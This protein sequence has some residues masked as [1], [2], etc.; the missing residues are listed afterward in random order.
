MR[1]IA[2][3]WFE[4]SVVL[5][6]AQSPFE[7]ADQRTHQVSH[8][9]CARAAGVWIVGGEAGHENGNYIEHFLTGFN[10]LGQ[11]V[12]EI[13]SMGIVM[14]MTQVPGT[15]VL[16]TGPHL[17]CDLLQPTSEVA[18][19][20]PA[21]N[22]IWSKDLWLTWAEHIDLAPDGRILV[23]GSQMVK[24]LDQFGD[25]LATIGLD[26]L[27][28]PAAS[29]CV[30]DSDST[31]MLVRYNGQLERRDLQAEV[32]AS[33][34]LADIQ[35]VV[36]WLDHRL[37]IGEDGIVHSLDDDL[38]E[39]IAVDLG[40][41][42]DKGS[43]VIDDSTIWV[44]GNIEATELDDSLAIIRTVVLDPDDIFGDLAF[45]DF[46]VD[47]D[48]ITMVGN[49][50]TAQRP[51][52]SIRSV[53]TDGSTPQH[54]EDVSIEILTVDSVWYDLMGMMVYPKARVTVM[55]SNEGGS[56]LDHVVVNHWQSFTGVC[57]NVGTTLHL[58]NLALA[59]GGSIDATLN[60]IWLGFAPWSWIAL[61]PDQEVCI[62]ALSPNS[63]YDRD[64]SDNLACDS[65]HIVLGLEELTAAPPFVLVQDGHALELRFHS[66]TTTD[67]QL[68][69]LDIS[70]RVRAEALIPRGTT[71]H[72]IPST[73]LASG[74][75][76]VRVCDA[77]RGCWTVKWVKE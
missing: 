11:P 75:H 69:L 26:S 36:R 43:I 68:Q 46:A 67:F 34:S 59:P 7:F 53:L 45:Q 58:E 1:H 37:V 49:P 72:R 57:S 64:Q 77:G 62:G 12:W 54:T 42:Y 66:P 8:V 55:V 41:P 24:L 14:D 13:P 44:I 76:L 2:L 47:G 10:G 74:V 73:G 20:D 40:A 51:A 48:T 22:V 71:I 56:L 23:S 27:G 3:A 18:L 60:E 4:F 32:L 39:L 52:G 65:V 29:W 25:S 28:F 5:A 16:V 19:L 33:T 63:I 15:G 61:N 9:A 38:V 70:G 17:A 35:D 6:V 31:M 30:W 50:M 21:G